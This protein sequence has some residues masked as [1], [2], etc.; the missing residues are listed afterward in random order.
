VN[1]E[2]LFASLLCL[3]GGILNF[4]GETESECGKEIKEER[5]ENKNK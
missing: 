4:E 2:N 1:V 3:G 5:K